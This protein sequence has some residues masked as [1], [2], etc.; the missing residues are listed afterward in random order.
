[1][2]D[3]L[4]IM[5]APLVTARRVTFRFDDPDRRYVRVGL[6]CEEAVGG[7]RRFRRTATGWT[8][9]IPRP[10]LDRF[11]YR[12]VLTGP[13]RQ[14]TQVCDPDNSERVRTAFGERSVVVAPE[15]TRPTWL[16][17]AVPPGH[18]VQLSHLDPVLGPL[19]VGLWSPAGLDPA[20]SAP[21]L[22]VHDGPEYADLSDLTGYAAAMTTSG[23]LPA[24]RM[25]LMHPLD[26][27]DWYA[28]NPDYVAA[29]LDALDTLASAAPVTGSP[30]VIGASLGGLSALL[31]ALAERSPFGGAVCQS[32][33]FF[34]PELDQQEASYPHFDRVTA[35]VD[36]I[37]RGPAP[38]H[39][40]VV[41]MTCGAWEDNLA[42]NAAMASALTRLGH[43]V[44][45]SAVADLH[46]YTAWRD[47][48][49]PA[50]TGVLRAVWSAE[51]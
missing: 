44:S 12:L 2:S 29:A 5:A 15:Y 39:R 45:F 16:S 50:L 31:V 46:N 26:R 9:R 35:A 19:P 28:A 48:L 7:R 43:Q 40:L 32:G 49:D 3:S 20:A 37:I 27:D 30:V 33:S 23:E 42:N 41:A 10:L 38:A 25:A 18:L 11:E 24:F 17:T 1:M 47:S 21:L 8:L 34:Q 22:V 6:D 51:G 36:A 14:T 4:S 13:D